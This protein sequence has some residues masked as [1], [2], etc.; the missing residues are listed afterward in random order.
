MVKNK[1]PAHKTYHMYI[2]GI[3]KKSIT[4]GVGE[5]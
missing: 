1:I 3:F 2:F 4:G 5:G